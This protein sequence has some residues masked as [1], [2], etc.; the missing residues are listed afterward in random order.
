MD[1]PHDLVVRTVREH[2]PSLLRTARRHSLCADD[3]HDAYQRGLEIFLRRAETLEPEAV[4][5]WLHQVV[6]HEAMAVRRQRQRLLAV[7]VADLDESAAAMGD[8]L[9]RVKAAVQ[10]GRRIATI[11]T[12]NHDVSVAIAA[13]DDHADRTA[14]DDDR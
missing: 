7:D 11:R 8:G 4:A 3:A 9:G 13:M 14:S 2:A 6:K 1:D 5:G 12:R 10:R